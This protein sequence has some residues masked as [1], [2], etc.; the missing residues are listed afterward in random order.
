MTKAWALTSL[1]VLA[2]CGSGPVSAASGHDASAPA[3]SPTVG[4]P[5]SAI[6]SSSAPPAPAQ[7]RTEC[8]S[9][10]YR[11][12]SSDYADDISTTQNDCLDAM[13]VVEGAPDRPNSGEAFVADGFSCT[14]GPETQA[15]SGGKASSVY[16]CVDNGG[17][18][19]TF[20]RY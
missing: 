13:K 14:A 4:Q 8:G 7:T 9:Y 6:S 20:R 17:V 5:T 12:Q 16:R 15:P 2:A 3:S 18:V 19:I 11:P 10:T 1:L